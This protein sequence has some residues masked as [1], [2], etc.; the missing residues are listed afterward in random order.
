MMLAA[1]ALPSTGHLDADGFSVRLAVLAQIG[2]PRAR[3][4]PTEVAG[5]DQIA[6]LAAE[7]GHRERAAVDDLE[8][9]REVT[10]P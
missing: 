6:G 4:A 2:D 7:D 3:F 10:V 1:S 5:V 8:V 9:A